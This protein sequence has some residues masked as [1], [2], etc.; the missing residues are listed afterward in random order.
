MALSSMIGR[1]IF[2]YFIVVL[3]FRFMGKREIGELSIV[4]LI[5]FFMM[6]EVATIAIEK[7]EMSLLQGAVPILT[8]AILQY[9][10]AYLSLKSRKV[11]KLFDGEPSIIIENG[12]IKDRMMRKM[13]YTLDDLLLQ[14]HDKDIVDISEVKF[15]VLE[16]NGKLSVIK[17]EDWSHEQPLLYPLIMDGEII[18]SALDKIGKDEQWLLKQLKQKGYEHSKQIFYCSYVN[19]RLYIHPYEETTS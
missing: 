17:K 11:R 18:G 16:T 13:R 7:A 9:V 1:T 10:I 8:L 2:F 6:S 3:V 4:D 15:A 12:K 14:L 5:V 19:Q